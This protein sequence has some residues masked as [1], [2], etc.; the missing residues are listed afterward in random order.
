MAIAIDDVLIIW[1]INKFCDGA[2]RKVSHWMFGSKEER[3]LRKAVN[4]A[5]DKFKGEHPVPFGQ[6]FTNKLFWDA[7]EKEF[8]YLLAPNKQPHIEDVANRFESVSPVKKKELQK[9][10]NRLFEIFREEIVKQPDLRAVEQI[11]LLFALENNLYDPTIDEIDTRTRVASRKDLQQLVPLLGIPNM[12]VELGSHLSSGKSQP[13]SNDDIVEFLKIGHNIILE[14]EPGAGKSTTL[15]QIAKSM[16]NNDEEVFP[17]FL[18]LPYWLSNRSFL[19]FIA[20]ENDAFSEQKL[21]VEDIRSLARHG[22]LVFI[23]DGW[24]ELSGEKLKEARI[25]IASLQKNYPNSGML[26]ATRSLSLPPKLKMNLNLTLNRLGR[27]K[28]NEIILNALGNTKAEELIAHIGSKNALRQISQTPFYLDKLIAVYQTNGS[29]P[30]TKEVLL[31]I[32]AHANDDKEAIV[33]ALSHRHHEYM[34]ALAVEMFKSGTTELKNDA[35]C[36]IISSVS[37]KLINDGQL[38]S[39]PDPQNILE[40][41]A[42]Y[43]LLINLS[44]GKSWKFQ[45]QQFQEWYASCWIEELIVSAAEGNSD[46]LQE[47]RSEVLNIPFWEEALFFAVERLAGQEDKQD[48]LA[49]IIMN[50]LEIDPLLAA[51]II[52]QSTGQVWT[53]VQDIVLDYIDRWH[54]PEKI[55]PDRSLSFMIA[56][57]RPEFAEKVWPLIANKNRQIRLHALRMYSPF[58]IGCLGAEWTKDL[59]KHSEEVQDDILSQIAHYGEI[60]ELELVTEL[61]IASPSTKIKVRVL[62]A[63]YFRC[64]Q[65][66]IQHILK[67]ADTDVWKRYYRLL[68]PEEMDEQA[69]AHGIAIAQDDLDSTTNNISRLRL[70]L[71]LLELGVKDI[72]DTLFESLA[73]LEDE[74]DPYWDLYQL[75]EQ[76][77]KIDKIQTANTLINRFIQGRKLGYRYEEFTLHADREHRKNLADFIVEGNGRFNERA[78]AARALQ[79]DGAILL[80][81]RLS[82]LSDEAASYP[83]QEVPTNLRKQ[84][85]DLKKTL[86]N[87]PEH[88]LV[89]GIVEINGSKWK[90]AFMKAKN[91]CCSLLGDKQR[92]NGSTLKNN[93]I[94][95]LA[96]LFAWPESSQ[97]DQAGSHRLELPDELSDSFR[98]ILKKWS[99]I[100]R[101]NDNGFGHRHE[102]S[103]ISMVLGRIGNEED[104]NLVNDLLQYDL[105]YRNNLLQE[106]ERSGRR[107]QRPSG[108]YMN[109]TNLYRCAFEAMPH[110]RVVEAVTPHLNNPEFCKEA[111]YIIRHAW[112]VEN[113]LL[114]RDANRSYPTDFSNVSE[115]MQKLENQERPVPHPYV[116]SVLNRIEE[117]LTQQEDEK[118]R[119]MI[120]DL[121]SAIADTEYGNKINIL[122]TVINIEGLGK[123]ACLMKLIQK[124]EKIG[125]ATIRPCCE[126]I[127]KEWDEQH[128]K[129][130]D[131]WYRVAEWLELLALSD[132]PM[133]VID[134]VKDLPKHMP[135]KRDFNRILN[136]LRYSSS[137]DAEKTLLS[138]AEAYPEL[139]KNDIWLKAMHDQLT[140]TS[141]KYFYEILW[142]PNKAKHYGRSSNDPFINIIEEIIKA[143]PEIR[144][145]FIEKFETPMARQLLNVMNY[146]LQRFKDDDEIIHASLL[147]LNNSENMLYLIKGYVTHQEPIDESSN[148]FTTVPFSATGI[149][150]RLLEM[151][152]GDLNRSVA[153]K[154]VLTAI[155]ELRDKH[156]RPEN[157]PRHPDLESDIPWPLIVQNE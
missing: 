11:R 122:E 59:E 42:K 135:Q 102:L 95:E 119:G 96:G 124:G 144:K 31:N 113:G 157:E 68:V 45:H 103:N 155:D 37:R 77:S 38:G 127:R 117:L 15:Y 48:V 67:N 43:H 93:H 139:E 149:R 52:A 88:F 16:L 19:E 39:P 36:Q 150:K 28:R 100:L 101:N 9:C 53:K 125:A 24:N 109:Y 2:L 74:Q 3:A 10:L 41:L 60:E 112:F 21:N 63:L 80:L 40:T 18:S 79:K 129:K 34:I 26:I 51:K 153:A 4:I 99:D 118:I 84:I 146:L 89:A 29:L 156:G 56:T 104:V 92:N 5:F 115:N 49:L 7:L 140:E 82:S 134:L 62:E 69:K 20:R 137:K 151:C 44:Y 87:I 123:Y 6:F 12:V 126:I 152:A 1:V 97:G 75:I 83:R 108:L 111:A 23:I 136:G 142:D 17:V 148:T 116:E 30:E 25:N 147:L 94:S 27:D 33:E 22:H 141:H 64:A 110:R 54:R 131:E 154:H 133:Q 90:L 130:T 128:L 65:T 105:N 106:R 58:H 85:D 70:C 145:D 143:N 132:D 78:T 91:F 50:A 121:A 46:S 73:N 32:C 98:D 71:Q 114:N 35:A 14:A 55:E 61:A 138:L 120:F 81:K 76:V 72:E 86:K 107:G 8:S 47:F 66:H 57:G 13:I